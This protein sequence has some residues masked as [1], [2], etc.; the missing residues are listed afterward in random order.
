MN[1]RM[2][3]SDASSEHPLAPVARS[4]AEQA[5]RQRDIPA[6]RRAA[7]AFAM[8]AGLRAVQL[9]DFV[10]AVSEAAG[11]AVAQG[12]CTARLRLWM[13][14]SRAFCEITA[15]GMLQAD[16]PRGGPRPAGEAEALRRWLLQRLCDH[17]SV[18][19]G[20]HGVTVILSM[21]VA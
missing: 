11:C 5:F 18:R 8:R 19:T 4:L 9:S 15:D 21:T 3:G 14:G 16:G 10:Q 12:P 1:T 6:V 7:A 2:R 13:M 20:P 17:V